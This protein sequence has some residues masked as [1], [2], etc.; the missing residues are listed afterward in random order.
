[1]KKVLI[2]IVLI[3][4]AVLVKETKAQFEYAGGGVALATGGEYKYDNNS[5]Y[6]K[7]FGIDLR[8]VYDYSKKLHIVPDFKFY[9]PYKESQT[10]GGEAKT[11]VIAFNVNAHYILNP[12]PRT[13]YRLYL[14]G[15]AHF[16]GWFIKDNRVM[17]TETLDV[18]E[19]KIS[20]GAN[21]G[22]GMQYEINANFIFF[23]EAKYIIA[24]TNQLVFN[25]GFLIVL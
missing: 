6:N 9:F 5:Y 14:L 4:L 17:L 20:P 8:A 3:M 10:I 12:K 7:S 18:N 11:T 21:V 19:F 25:P 15:G 24:K 16:S 13:N 23:A 1:M 22:A 2:A